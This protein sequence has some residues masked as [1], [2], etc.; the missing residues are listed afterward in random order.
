MKSQPAAQSPA[1]P[2]EASASVPGGAAARW[3]G[4][5]LGLLALGLYLLTNSPT[6]NFTDSGE[7]IAVAWTGGIAHPPGYPLY[8][9]LG[10]LAIRLPFGD[11][12]WRMN[13]LSVLFAAAAVSLFYGL[14]ANTLAGLPARIQSGAARTGRSTATP[15]DR[16]KQRRAASGSRPSRQA[17]G[18]RAGSGGK[19]RTAASTRVERAVE[20]EAAAGDGGLGMWPAVAGGIAAAGLLAVSLTFWNWATQAKFY[21]LHYAFAAALL[22]LA[23]RVRGALASPTGGITTAPRWSPAAWPPAVRL[24]HLLAFLVGLSLTNHF[25]TFLLLPGIVVL[26]ITP[27]RNARANLSVVLRHAVTLIAAAL[28]PLLLYLYLPIRASADPLIEWGLPET[29][30]NFWRHVTARGYQGFFGGGDLGSRLTDAFIYA[31]NQFGPW[32]GLLLL[33]PVGIGLVHLWR[34]DRGLLAATVVLALTHLVVVLNYSIREIVTYYVPLYMVVLWWAGVGVGRGVAW[35]YGRLA[36]PGAAPSASPRSAAVALAV[37]VVLPLVALAVNWGDAGHRGNYTAELFARNAFKNF[38]QD[39]V[40]LTNYWDLTSTSFYLQ[41]V[42]NERPDV[43]IIDKST[44]RDPFYLEYLE[45]AQPDV[46]SRNAAFPEYKA[47]LQEWIDSGRTPQRLPRAYLDVLNGFIDTNAGQRPVY[48]V[49]VAPAGDVQEREEI[50][51]LFQNRQNR[52]VPDG[53]GHRLAVTDDDLRAQDPQFDLRGIT[54]DRVP[55]DEIE[56]A[57]IALYPPSLEAI[58]AY[59]Q[60]ST[61][62]ED[63]ELGERLLAQARELAPLAALQDARPRLR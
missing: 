15:G 26:L 51:A 4:L 22:W 44:L 38:R 29:W 58:G 61:A 25:L 32:L 33:V 14:V 52:L 40:V 11:P 28:V 20:V 47:L 18:D 7:L 45:R 23:L 56:A 8:T 34:A 24:L 13:L 2:A 12:A 50:A 31:A 59:M 57:T 19:G 62:P 3:A 27:W 10:S 16:G 39:A 54:T 21:T 42:L 43:T 55:L 36:S 35:L 60:N 6:V 46:V 30:S 48:F 41:H 37:G 63:R 49:F 1:L 9:L 17:A 5:A 53:L